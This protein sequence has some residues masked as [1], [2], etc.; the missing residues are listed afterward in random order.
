[1]MILE[2][3]TQAKKRGAKIRAYIEGFGQTSDA[4][5]L[6]DGREDMKGVTLAM[7]KAL[8]VAGVSPEQ[9]DY[10]NAH[11]TST[12]K[13]DFLE[14]EGIK[15]V[16][17]KRSYDIPVSSLKSQVGHLNIACGIVETIASILMLEEQ[18][19]APT[20]NWESD[21]LCDL[22]YVPNKSVSHQMNYILKNSFG[23]GGANAAVVLRRG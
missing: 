6:T 10:I 1:M 12:V 7:Q 11:G 21:P 4:W 8:K 22:N 17:G 5:R 14:S 2:D 13:N 18:R 19:I 16:F 20:I 9:I 3:A 15:A 23:F